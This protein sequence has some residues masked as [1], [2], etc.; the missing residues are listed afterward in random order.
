MDNWTTRKPMNIQGL[1]THELHEPVKVPANRW[2]AQRD[3]DGTPHTR[4][5]ASALHPPDAGP[6]LVIG[7]ARPAIAKALPSVPKRKLEDAEAVVKAFLSK[8]DQAA[9]VFKSNEVSKS[10]RTN[11]EESGKALLAALNKKR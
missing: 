8:T 6:T 10:L 11:V 9:A 5:G 1:F 2:K 3:A 4:H 7:D